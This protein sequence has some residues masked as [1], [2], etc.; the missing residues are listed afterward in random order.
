MYRKVSVYLTRLFSAL[1]VATVLAALLPFATQAAAVPAITIVSVKP[2]ESVTIKG[3]NFPRNLNFTVRM[4]VVGKLAVGGLV[5]GWTN[6][7]SGSFEAT[8]SIPASLKHTSRLAIRLDS[9]N[10]AYSY[11]WFDNVVVLNPT[12]TPSTSSGK[13]YILILAVDKDKTVTVQANRFPANQEFT[14]RVG[15]FYTFF[16]DGETVARV[17][18]GEGGSFTFTVN[19]PASAR[20]VE[21][22]TVRMDSVQG[23]YAFNA[24][25]NVSGGVGTPVVPT[26]TPVTPNTGCEIVSVSPAKSVAARADFDVVWMVKNTGSKAWISDS[27][28]Y[29][30]ISGV[31]MHQVKGY[32]LHQN[33][34]PGETVKI[35]VDMSAP[36]QAGTYTTHWAVV[37]NNA[38]TL[39]KLPFTL[40]VK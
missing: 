32:D 9:A 8:Y 25:T 33:V 11:N 6:S 5:A 36:S 27:V 15:P 12:T 16:K 13:A 39:C 31:Q 20:G 40:T 21:L 4:D 1:M 10:G 35:V 34:K 2:G 3:E 26:V 38:T 19:L 28:D 18:S 14:V 29:K 23:V 37:L 17:N 22:V 7:G 30:Y 24:F